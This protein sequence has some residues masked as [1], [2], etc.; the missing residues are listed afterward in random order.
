MP[1]FLTPGLLM[2]IAVLGVFALIFG[3]ATLWRRG[4]DRQQS[5]LMVIAA[6]VLFVNILILSWP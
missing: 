1:E 2:S 6:I 5:L 4:G 3:A